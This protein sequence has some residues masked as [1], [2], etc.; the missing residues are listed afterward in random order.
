MYRV[1]RLYRV[2]RVFR[3]IGF[4]VL[5]FWGYRVCDITG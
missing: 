3:T 2:S 5:G 4:G 1:Y